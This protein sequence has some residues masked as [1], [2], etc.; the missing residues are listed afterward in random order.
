MPSS[1]TLPFF[2][3][4]KKFSSIITSNSNIR[5]AAEVQ[6]PPYYEDGRMR[7]CATKFWEVFIFVAAMLFVS[8]LDPTERFCQSHTD[9]FI[10]H[11]IAVF[12]VTY[13]VRIPLAM[14]I[15]AILSGRPRSFCQFFY[16]AYYRFLPQRTEDS[17]AKFILSED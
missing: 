7:Y 10:L 1:E 13:F 14:I 11:G 17:L 2:Q 4:E 9:S 8:H 12:L 16:Q 5:I 15:A 6:L 3:R